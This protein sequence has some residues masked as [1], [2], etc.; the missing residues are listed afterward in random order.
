MDPFDWMWAHRED[1]RERTREINMTTLTEAFCIENDMEDELDDSLS[2][3]W[4]AALE[5]E[6]KD[7]KQR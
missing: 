4:D 6:E 3:V 2:P 5:V 1:H 7:S